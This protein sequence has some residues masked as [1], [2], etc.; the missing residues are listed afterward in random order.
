MLKMLSEGE[1]GAKFN[2]DSTCCRVE[3]ANPDIEAL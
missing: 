3:C 1:N 2:S